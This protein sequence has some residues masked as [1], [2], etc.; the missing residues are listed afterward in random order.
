MSVEVS[1]AISENLFRTT[2]FDAE[3]MV[4]VESGTGAG[5]GRYNRHS[6]TDCSF[7]V[8]CLTAGSNSSLSD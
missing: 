3:L 1:A 6:R 5:L 7:R 2:A 4:Y 8:K